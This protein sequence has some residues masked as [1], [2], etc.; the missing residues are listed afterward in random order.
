MQIKI[1]RWFELDTRF[2][3]YIKLPYVGAGHRYPGW[4]FTHAWTWSWWSEL[5]AIGEV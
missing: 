2:G 5:R 4:G 3:L 1:G